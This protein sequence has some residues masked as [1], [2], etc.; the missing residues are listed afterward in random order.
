MIIR[1]K[2]KERGVSEIEASW[3][4]RYL[5]SPLTGCQKARCLKPPGALAEAKSTQDYGCWPVVSDRFDAIFKW[6]RGIL[7]TSSDSSC[8]CDVWIFEFFLLDWCSSVPAQ[9]AFQ[10]SQ[11][12]AGS[13]RTSSLASPAAMAKTSHKNFLAS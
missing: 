8:F 13:F 3:P 9:D 5:K 7:W 11:L 6:R 2:M 12:V 1:R 4:P 10:T